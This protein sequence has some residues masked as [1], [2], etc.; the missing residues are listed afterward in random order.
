MR[1]SSANQKCH[2]QMNCCLVGS[3]VGSF[4]EGV[5]ALSASPLEIFL[6][7]DEPTLTRL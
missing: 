7:S 5:Y 4:G 2:R 3:G 1:F 6:P